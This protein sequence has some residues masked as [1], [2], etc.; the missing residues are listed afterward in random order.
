MFAWDA[1]GRLAWML[2][3]CIWMTTALSLSMAVA[4]PIQRTGSLQA[5]LSNTVVEWFDAL[6]C[7]DVGTC[8][9]CPTP[10]LDLTPEWLRPQVRQGHESH[11]GTCSCASVPYLSCCGQQHWSEG[12]CGWLC[13]LVPWLARCGRWC[14]NHETSKDPGIRESFWNKHLGTLDLRYQSYNHF[15]AGDIPMSQDRYNTLTQQSHR[16]VSWLHVVLFCNKIDFKWFHVGRI[17]IPWLRCTSPSHWV[18]SLSSTPSL[19]VRSE[20]RVWNWM[21]ACWPRSLAVRS[22]LGIMQTSKRIL[23]TSNQ[24]QV[25]CNANKRAAHG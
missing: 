25:V 14:W 16:M 18:Q 11:G 15:G 7:Q 22:L 20:E 21:H 1:Q 10:N 6:W 2:W 24:K 3:S 12:V 4:P 23:T 8:F 13:Q 5:L 17:A 19:L 9:T